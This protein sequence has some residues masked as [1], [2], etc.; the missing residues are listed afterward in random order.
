MQLIHLLKRRFLSAKNKNDFCWLGLFAE[1]I[2]PNDYPKPIRVITQSSVTKSPGKDATEH[3]SS[4]GRTRMRN[5]LLEEFRDMF[6]TS[7]QL[8]TMLDEPMKIHLNENVET[9]AISATR[10]IPSA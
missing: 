7:D 2:L 10:S 4:G 9:F 5:D 1:G 6:D 3:E 8:K